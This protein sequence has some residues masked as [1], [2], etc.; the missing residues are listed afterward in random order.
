MSAQRCLGH[1]ALAHDLQ[2][3]G[4]RLL[5]IL[6]RRGEVLVAGVDPQV[7]AG[8]LHD[9]RRLA[10]MV[11]VGVGA[12]EQAHLLDPQADLVERGVYGAPFR[13]AV[14]RTFEPEVLAPR[15]AQ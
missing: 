4:Q 1:S 6:G 11:D 5:G 8:A 10:A 15:E 3:A 13:A 2:P 9:R 14:E 7:A 12:D